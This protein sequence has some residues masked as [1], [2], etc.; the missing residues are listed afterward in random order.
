MIESIAKSKNASEKHKM[1]YHNLK[2]FVLSSKNRL[3]RIKGGSRLAD[4][5]DVQMQENQQVGLSDTV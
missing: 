2:F 1:E 4:V 5:L 3:R